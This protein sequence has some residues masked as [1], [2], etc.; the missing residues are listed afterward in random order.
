MYLC[1]GHETGRIIEAA[2]QGSVTGLTAGIDVERP[3]VVLSVQEPIVSTLWA[4]I[5]IIETN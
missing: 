4:L 5:S 1:N 3:R 2:V